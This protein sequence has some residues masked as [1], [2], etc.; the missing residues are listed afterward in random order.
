LTV[1]KL[2]Y[3]GYLMYDC[4]LILV[5]NY[6]FSNLSMLCEMTDVLIY[7]YLGVY[8]TV[9]LQILMCVGV[10]VCSV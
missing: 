8:Y 6:H 10:C 3:Y 1:G 4:S 9:I 2:V 7:N 5:V